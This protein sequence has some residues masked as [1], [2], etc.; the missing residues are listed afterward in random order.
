[1]PS[2]DLL[3]WK[4]ANHHGPLFLVETPFTRVG[5][6]WTPFRMTYN[7]ATTHRYQF[8]WVLPRGGRYDCVLHA[9]RRR[10]RVR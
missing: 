9:I 8:E 3:I 4:F 2:Y 7:I 5:E 6:I 1:M 10:G